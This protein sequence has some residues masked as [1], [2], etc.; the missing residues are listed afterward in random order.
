MG[1]ATYQLL[2]TLLEN[3]KEFLPSNEEIEKNLLEF[4]KKDKNAK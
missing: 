3:L 1:A 2:N 4:L